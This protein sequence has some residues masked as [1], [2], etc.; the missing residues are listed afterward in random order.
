M[1]KQRFRLWQAAVLVAAAGALLPGATP[2]LAAAPNN[3]QPAAVTENVTQAVTQSYNADPSVQLGMIVQLKN[4]DTTSVAPLAQNSLA[5]ML[6]VVVAGND[7][8][9]TLTPQ[10]ASQQ[11][12]FVATSGRYSTLVSNQNG[13]IKAGDFITISSLAGVGMRADQ[14]QS[15]VLGKAAQGFSGTANV[16]GNTT[17][18]DTSGHSVQISLGKIAIDLD[19][20]H[21]PLESRATDYVPS[22]LAKAAVTV[23]NR[24]VSAARIYLGLLTLLATA[25]VTANLLYSGVRSGMMAIGRN[26]LSKKSIIRSLVQTVAAGLIIFVI[27]VF[28]VYLLLKL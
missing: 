8:T 20:A 11:Q 27:G 22:F 6:G 14:S 13:P 5:N 18:K 3:A 25:V 26:P 1:T 24:P 23:A 9:V 12:V 17:L 4:K 15:I 10:N 21:N 28:A 2:V 19:I 7:A 16:V